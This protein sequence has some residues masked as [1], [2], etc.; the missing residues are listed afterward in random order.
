MKTFKQRLDFALKKRGLSQA[1]FARL[2][3]VEPQNI[4]HWITRNGI[5][6]RKLF[7]ASSALKV[8]P[9]WLSEGKGEWNK[10][11]GV[12]ANP[13]QHTV[14]EDKA[15]YEASRKD[16][17]ITEDEQQILDYYRNM[18][19][20]NRVRYKEVGIVFKQSDQALKKTDN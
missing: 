19:K 20:D 9:E 17:T 14:E 5:S 7:E 18:S 12:T 3:N 6:R 10:T 13:I 8:N 1:E 16:A 4:T 11:S 2:I 15:T